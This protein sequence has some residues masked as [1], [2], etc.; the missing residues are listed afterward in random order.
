[1]SG[2]ATVG[3]TGAPTGADCTFPGGTSVNVNAMQASPFTVQ[4]TTTSRTM[5]AALPNRTMPWRWMWPIAGFVLLP[6]SIARKRP[7]RRAVWVLP[8]LMLVLLCAC[9]GGGSSTGGSGSSNPNGT[10]AGTYKLT[11]TATLGSTQES[12]PLTLTVQ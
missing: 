11:V 2:T 12:I 5:A 10:P 1:M 6:G 4:V 8:F 7:G 3:C 9:G